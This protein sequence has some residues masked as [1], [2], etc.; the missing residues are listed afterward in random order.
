MRTNL[1]FFFVLLLWHS[2]ATYVGAISA[3]SIAGRLGWGTLSDYI[4]RKNTWTV[5]FTVGIPLYLVVP[6]T[7]HAVSA[8]DSVAPLVLFYGST[9]AIFTMYGGCFSTLPAYIGDLFGSKFVGGIHGRMLTAWSVAAMAGPQLLAH[10]RKSS[11]ESAILDLSA[12]VDP[13]V[14]HRTFG[15]SMGDLHHLIHAKT[16]TVQNLLA[17]SPPGTVDP[18]PYLYDTTM[19]TMAGLLSV[20]VISNALVKP[21]AAK[22][23]MPAEIPSLE[24]T[25]SRSP[26]KTPG[27][28]MN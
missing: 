7:A 14:F 22:W 12:K 5:L 3:A 9:M 15:S 21:V 20:A 10:L 23:H 6:Y 2:C 19:Y 17:I 8:S 24:L 11:A 25:S 4:G 16:V 27:S 13:A 26:C 28:R 1:L 18:T